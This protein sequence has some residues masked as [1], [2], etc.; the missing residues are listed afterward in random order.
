MKSSHERIYAVVCGIPR[1]RV[2]TYGQ[3]VGDQLAT[4]IAFTPITV[5]G[6]AMLYVLWLHWRHT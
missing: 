6:L 3:V 4:A 1:G 2:A 5:C